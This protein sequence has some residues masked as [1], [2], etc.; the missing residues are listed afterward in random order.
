MAQFGATIEW[1]GEDIVFT[2]NKYSRAHEWRFDGGLRVPASSSPLSVRVP[3]SDPTAIDPE[4]AL[5]ASL[6]SCHML[7]FLSLAAKAGFKVLRYVDAP[8]GSS[9]NDPGGKEWLERV[10][11]R[12]KVEFRGGLEPKDGDVAAL[13]AKAH[14]ECFIASSIRAEVLVN[15]SWTYGV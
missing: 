9:G 7:W 3:F 5:V 15:G 4:E 12:P 1:I 11:L 8:V 6:A 13:H 10:E 2:D 14:E